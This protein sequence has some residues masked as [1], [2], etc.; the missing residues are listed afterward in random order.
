MSAAELRGIPAAGGVAVGRAVVLS[1]PEAE[2]GGT[3]GERAR[4]DALAALDA[5]AAELDESAEAL[6]REGLAAEAEILAANALMASD[7]RE[8]R[9]IEA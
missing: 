9:K 1:E 3:G 6:R 8:W 5:V 2:A 4:A 7:G